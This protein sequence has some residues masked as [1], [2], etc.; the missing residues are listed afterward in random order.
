[1]VSRLQGRLDRIEQQAAPNLERRRSRLIEI[2]KLRAYI[3]P[4]LDGVMEI[5]EY[6]ELSNPIEL[7]EQIESDWIEQELLIF[8]EYSERFGNVEKTE[9]N[10]TEAIV[11]SDI[12][13]YR[14]IYGR[15]YSRDDV[16]QPRALTQRVREDMS[17]RVQVSESEAAQEIIRSEATRAERVKKHTDAFAAFIA[18]QESRIPD[19]TF[20]D[21]PNLA[22]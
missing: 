22:A 14:E 10:M 2:N 4:D 5:A 9:E 1:M 13:F 7:R 15:E 17:N 20:D 16:L 11:E 6:C 21:S 18:G 12:K 19:W 3:K 8:A